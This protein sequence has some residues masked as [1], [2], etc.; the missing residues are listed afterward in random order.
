MYDLLKGLRVVEGS[1]FI[2]GPTCGLYL[3]QM[4]AQVIR[5]DNIAGGPDFRR[6]PLAQNG[7]S[8][9]WEGLNKAKKSVALDLSR[10]EGRELAQ[11]LAAAPGEAGGLFV[12]N[13]PAEGFLA[14]E[15]LKALRDDLICVRVMGWAD[16]GPG[17]DYTIN[18]AVGVPQMTGPTDDD[19]PVNH[20]LPAW[21]LLTGAYAAF[22]LVSALLDRRTSG[23]GREI[24]IPLSDIAAATLANMGMTAEAALGGHQRAR[25]GN[26]LYG[27]FGRDFVTRGGQRIMLVAIT[28]RQWKGVLAVLGIAE[29]VAALEAELACDFVADEGQRFAHRDRLFPLFEQAFAARDLAELA[30]VFEADGVCWGPY[31]PL[32]TAMADPRLFAGN[33][34]FSDLT[35]PSGQTYPAAGAAATI[36][37]DV[38]GPARPA[39]RLGQH[40]DEVLAEVLGMSGAEIARLHDAGIVAG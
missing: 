7:S 13:F 24:R 15:R 37:Q 38:R 4:G 2:A 35:H 30:P 11:R 22:T 36:P 19:R 27:A 9:Y 31:Q 23:R 5:F 6:W 32:E 40:T 8:L 26:D 29:P 10:P 21:D 14:Y 34:I 18:A 16:G 1:A 3:A 20:V 39:A 12:T 33:P 25:H 17:V 28:P